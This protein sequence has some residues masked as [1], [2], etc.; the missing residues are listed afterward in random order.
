MP[1]CSVWLTFWEFASVTLQHCNI[2]DGGD[3]VV[4]TAMKMQDSM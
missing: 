3:E 2:R 4:G 1:L